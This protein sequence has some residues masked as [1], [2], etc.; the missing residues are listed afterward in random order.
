MSFLRI[1]QRF[2]LNVKIYAHFFSRVTDFWFKDLYNN[3]KDV[4][5]L[6]IFLAANYI[7]TALILMKN[8]EIILSLFIKMN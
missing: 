6:T 3:F 8:F 1:S 2:I 7:I 5:R 4:K